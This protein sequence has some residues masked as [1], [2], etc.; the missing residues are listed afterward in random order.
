MKKVFDKTQETINWITGILLV[1][2]CVIIFIQVVMRKFFGQSFSWSEELT[3]YFF[4]CIIYLGVN[5]GI[6]DNMQYNIDILETF[7]KGPSKKVLRII[8][9]VIS[10][11]ACLAAAYG[12]FFLVQVGFVQK[13]PTLQVLMGIIYLVFPI[14][15]ALDI[16]EMIRRIVVTV[17][18][19]IT[20]EEVE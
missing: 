5:L 2:L 16:I 9:H 17:K 19:P 11:T 1:A 4:V 8:Q 12:S 13:S 6:R 7:V 10:I 14:G 3:R 18:E 15:F 20:A